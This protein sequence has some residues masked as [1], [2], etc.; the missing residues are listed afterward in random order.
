MSEVDQA[1]TTL[2]KEIQAKIQELNRLKE[3]VSAY[4]DLKR[5]KGRWEKVAYYSPSVN[6]LVKN[7]D[8]RHNCGCCADSPL[9]IWPFIETPQGKVYSD[10]PCFTIGERSDYGDVPCDDWE[11]ALKKANIPEEIIEHL[12]QYFES[13]KE[14]ALEYEVYHDV[15]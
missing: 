9:E 2:E 10:P 12:Q 7:Y 15:D 11:K 13:C 14:S 6:S 5:Y 8:K 3:L 4:P 1:I